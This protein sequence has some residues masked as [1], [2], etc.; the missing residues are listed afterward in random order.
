MREDIKFTY[1]NTGKIYTQ[2]NDDM[3]EYPHIIPLVDENLEFTGIVGVYSKNGWIFEEE[4]RF[5]NRTSERFKYVFMTASGPYFEKNYKKLYKNYDGVMALNACDRVHIDGYA[6][7]LELNYS[8]M[9]RS[10][11]E[12]DG[13]DYRNDRHYDMDFSIL[14]WYKDRNAKVWQD[15]Y[16][17]IVKLCEQGYKGIL[18]NQR[19]D[20]KGIIKDRRL[21]K[22]IEKG[23]LEVY[24]TLRQR[25]FHDL[26]CRARVGIF[27]N[28]S[29]AF[30]K[31]IIECLLEDKPVVISSQ[32]LFGVDTLRNLGEEITLVQNFRDR[33]YLD[34][35]IKFIDKRKLVVDRISPR[36]EWL[37][38]YGFDKLSKIWA[39]EFEKLEGGQNLHERIFC[40]RHIPRF[41]ADR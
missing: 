16:K 21:N 6:N 7:N 2:I 1:D 5:I 29:D 8:M 36:E 31:N 23:N 22:Y 33:N 32:L 14:T 10:G 13:F 27:P 38:R 3:V 34:N 19:G 37:N 40:M 39:I 15:A 12:I 28:R 4:R 17:T 18:V 35:I 41:C 30:P 20:N 11:P 24:G 9:A 25:E 26:M